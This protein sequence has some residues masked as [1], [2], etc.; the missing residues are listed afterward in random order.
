[1]VPSLLY[2]IVIGVIKSHKIE[3]LFVIFY[4]SYSIFLYSHVP[5]TVVP[6]EDAA[7][8]LGNARSWLHNTPLQSAYRPPLISWVIAAEWIF[9]GENLVAAAYLM[10]IFTLAAGIILFILLRKYKGSLFAFSVS[11]LTLLNP[12]VFFWSTETLTESLSLFFIILSLYF[13]K[14]E[15]QSH[16]F[17]AGISMGL[18]IASR[19]PMLVEVMSIFIVECIIRKSRKFVIRSIIGALPVITIVIL[20]VFFKTGTFIAS[21]EQGTHFIL[22][23]SF[24]L[25]KS[26]DIWGF[27]FLLVPVAFLFKR[28]YVD[29]Y[30]YAFISW[31][32]VS[33]LFWSSYSNLLPRYVVQFTPAVYYLAMLAI[34]N[35]SRTNFSKQSITR[36]LSSFKQ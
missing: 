21:Q 28:T 13:I 14:S 25:Q 7:D 18:T 36:Y 26:I 3:A 32:I 22:P 6:L 8:Y 12:Q 17:F 30:N 15:K 11:A 2:T 31:F 33:L 27:S 5:F 1:M 16:W 4:T 23:S 35:I 9:T 20:A 29:T 24:Y 19:T 10:P 34:E